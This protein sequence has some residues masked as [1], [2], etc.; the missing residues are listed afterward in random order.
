MVEAHIW[1]KFEKVVTIQPREEK[2]QEGDLITA[3]QYF[4]SSNRE[5]EAAFCTRKHGTDALGTGANSVS[6]H[7]INLHG[8]NN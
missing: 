3:F 4:K 7:E 8:G 2:T 6:V 5:G 1:E